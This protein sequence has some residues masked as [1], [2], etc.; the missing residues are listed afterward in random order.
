VKEDEPIHNNF[1]LE[2]F[3]L[4]AFLQEKIERSLGCMVEAAPFDRLAS[5]DE[6]PR[7]LSFRHVHPCLER[8]VHFICRDGCLIVHQIDGEYFAALLDR[9]PEHL[10]VL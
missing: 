6:N 7:F 4:Q 1:D 8:Q 9:T 10:H 3:D 2:Q 5:C